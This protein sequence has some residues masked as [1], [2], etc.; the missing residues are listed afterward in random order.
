VSSSQQRQPTDYPLELPIA[1]GR[2]IRFLYGA[3]ALIWVASLIGGLFQYVLD[4]DPEQNRP[5]RVYIKL[6]DIDSESNISTW[7]QSGLLLIN[8]LA[9]LSIAQRTRRERDRWSRHWA[10]LAL[11]F[12]YLSL[13]EFAVLHEK[14]IPIM[15]RAFNLSGALALGWVLLAVPA[16]IIF[17][18]L[19][20]RFLMAL[21]TP[22]RIG[23]IVAGGLYV[24]G[25]AGFEL[26]EAA[27][28]S[29]MGNDNLLYVLA[30]HA[31]E[32]LE[33]LG[34]VLLLATVLGYA[35]QRA[36]E[37]VDQPARQVLTR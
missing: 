5:L 19:F 28:F 20:V 32:L 10:L 13:D 1:P 33:M 6:I 4:Y 23:F 8:A 25:A 11:A 15:R 37:H 14:T 35:R 17:G 2:S 26:V 9:L 36:E 16:V 24:G 18:L 21:P 30:A 34:S 12:A 27:V 22:V 3:V 31:Q 7:F 29:R